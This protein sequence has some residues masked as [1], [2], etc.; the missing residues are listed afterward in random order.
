MCRQYLEKLN[1]R[2]KLPI[3]YE[4]S[5]EWVGKEGTIDVIAQDA[6]GRTLVALC[7]WEKP[8]MTYADYEWVLSCAEKAKIRV[9][10]IYLYTASRFDEKL[11]L[12][13]KIKKNL[14]L[15]QVADI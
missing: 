13:A 10:Y 3:R 5:G 11:D 7:N 2:G 6:N 4:N 15:V 9:D 1:E 8:M 14:R 12:E